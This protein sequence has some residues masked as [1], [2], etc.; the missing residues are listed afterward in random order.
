M[1]MRVSIGQ[2]L[3]GEKKRRKWID[4]VGYS[5][6][7][8]KTHLERQFAKGMTWQNYGSAWH[9]DHIIPLRV[10]NYRAADDPDFVR[11]WGLRNLRPLWAVD[12]LHKGGRL[13]A[14]FQPSL[15]LS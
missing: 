15:A 10:F 7:Q 3:R 12:N 1:V 2:C 9:I 8:L 14:T 6:A 4:L 5:V 11:A 13:D